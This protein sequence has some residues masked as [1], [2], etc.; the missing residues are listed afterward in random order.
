ML[1]HNGNAIATTF[2]RRTERDQLTVLQHP[3]RARLMHAPYDLD[4]SALASPVLP[5]ERMNATR[6]KLQADL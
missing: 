3:T 2:K 6:N 1:V 4:E 5:G